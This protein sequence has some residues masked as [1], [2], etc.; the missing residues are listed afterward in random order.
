MG[1]KLVPIFMTV[2]DHNAPFYPIWLLQGLL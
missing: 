2:N 1:F